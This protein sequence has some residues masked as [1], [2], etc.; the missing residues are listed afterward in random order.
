[1]GEQAPVAY[2]YLE[3]GRWSVPVVVEGYVAYGKPQVTVQPGVVDQIHLLLPTINSV[4]HMQT[5]LEIKLAPVK[6]E[7]KTLRR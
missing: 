4:L 6:M 5:E 7:T 2:C 3:N 1:M